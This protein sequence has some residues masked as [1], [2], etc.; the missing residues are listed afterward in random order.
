MYYRLKP[1]I[2]GSI[3][4]GFWERL[5]SSFL[6]LP[7]RVIEKIRV[8]VR[9]RRDYQSLLEMPDYLLDDVGLTRDEIRA[10]RKQSF[11]R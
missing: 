2:G 1:A 6:A 7:S 11:F 9:N 3:D 5:G 8:H 4:A 10:E